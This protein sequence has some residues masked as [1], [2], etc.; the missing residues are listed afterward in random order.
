MGD[1]EV[2]GYITGMSAAAQCSG[3]SGCGG[4]SGA[5]DGASVPPGGSM[6]PPPRDPKEFLERTSTPEGEIELLKEAMAGKPNG[7]SWTE[8][9]RLGRAGDP[10]Y[11]ELAKRPLVAAL[12][13]MVTTV[14]QPRSDNFTPPE[15]TPW[16]GKR[17]VEDVKAGLGFSHQYKIVGESW[18]ISSHES[19][20]N[21]FAL[22]YAGQALEVT[23]SVLSRIFSEEMYGRSITSAHDEG[24]P[25]LVKL[26]NSGS[27]LPY[28]DDLKKMFGW[29]DG[30]E[31]A[32]GWRRSL[33]VDCSFT[34]MLSW[35]HHALHR[36]IARL[37]TMML[38]RIHS[39]SERHPQAPIWRQS[40]NVSSLEN[41]KGRSTDELINAL[42]LLSTMQQAGGLAEEAGETDHLALLHIIHQKMLTKNL[43][44]QVHPPKGYDRLSPGEHSKSEAWI[45]L[46]S[47]PGAGIYLGIKEGVTKEQFASAL[48]A[49]EDV[50]NLLNFIQVKRGDVFFIPAGTMHA[51]G[52]GVLLMEPQETSETTY[53]VY[54]YG[55]LDANKR[56][57]ELKIDSAMAVTEWG[58]KRGEDAVQWF[59][60]TPEVMNAGNAG[61]ARVERVLNETFFETARLTFGRGASHLSD[62]D[63]SIKAYTVVE[64]AVEVYKGD[65]GSPVGIYQKGQ[66]FIIPVAMG[67]YRMTGVTDGA[68]VYETTVFSLDGAGR[69]K[70]TSSISEIIAK[71]APEMQSRNAQFV[72]RPSRGHILMINPQGYA[73]P[74]VPMSAPDTGGQI[75]YLHSKARM[76]A[77]MGYKVSIVTRSFKPDEQY[78]SYGDRMG[79]DFLSG[80]GDMVRYVFVPGLQVENAPFYRKEERHFYS[81]LPSMARN[82]ALFVDDEARTQKV[83]PWDYFLYV[84]THY[85]DGGKVGQRLVRIWDHMFVNKYF[86][87][88]F[89]AVLGMRSEQDPFADDNIMGNLPYYFGKRVMAAWYDEMGSQPSYGS[90][91]NMQDVLRWAATKL[92]WPPDR[93]ARLLSNST[94]AAIGNGRHMLP[95][96]FDAY[97]IG[98]RLLE[99]A[100][101]LGRLFRYIKN[102]NRHVWTP[103]SLGQLK[104]DRMIADNL[105]LK[106]PA[107]F[108]ALNFAQR[109]ASERELLSGSLS[110]TDLSGELIQ[111]M[112]PAK[113]VVFT[114]VEIAEAAMR[115]GMPAT[116][117]T[118]SFVPGTDP[119]QYHQRDSVNHPDIQLL[120]ND[121][122]ERGVVPA[123]ILDALM[124]NPQNFNVI[125]EAGRMD[126]SKR[127][128]LLIEAMASLPPNTVMLI[129]GGRDRAGIYDG[130]K[131]RIERLGLENRV[132]LLGMVP[133][134]VMGPLMSIPHG[135]ADDQFRLA[136]VASA[137]G[138]EGWGMAVQDGT[139]GGMPLVGSDRIPYAVHL[140]RAANA[141]V[142][143]PS[144]GSETEEVARYAEALRSMIDNPPAARDT[145]TRSLKIAQQYEWKTLTENAMAQLTGLLFMSGD[146]SQTMVAG[147]AIAVGGSKHV[148]IFAGG[149][150]T[151]FRPY[152]SDEVPKQFLPITHQ[153]RTM[154]Q[155]TAERFK[156]FVPEEN[157]WISTNARHVDL[158]GEQLPNVPRSNVIGEPVARNTAPAIASIMYWI[159]R[160]DPEA[161]VLL[162]PA[163]HFIASTETLLGQVGE[164]YEYAAATGAL[165][166][167][168]IPPTWASP[169]YGYIERGGSDA[170]YTDIYRVRRFVEKPDAKKAQTYLDGGNF[171]WNS[172]MFVWS[173]KSFL[174]NLAHYQPLMYAG[175][176]A[177]YGRSSVEA[178]LTSEMMERFFTPLHPISI[179]YALMEPA[180]V[181]NRVVVLPFKS[182]WSDV[183]TWQS[184]DRMVREGKAA[185]PEVV[186]EHM[187][188]KLAA[189]G[190]Q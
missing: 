45:I 98:F 156:G 176:E 40:L 53:R 179:D 182:D 108:H 110:G 86:K 51:I 155:V 33:D 134:E 57:R 104:E 16:G 165:L 151:R 64:G 82:L 63:G 119:Q 42:R 169:E 43:S 148:V 2:L 162:V 188:A 35:D 94:G 103:H 25:F 65:E 123:E 154:L 159:A 20:P 34:E 17:I 118:I 136:M 7:I 190:G 178:S 68:T 152:S 55:R 75:T 112:P 97:T 31:Y 32:A 56:P 145:A 93:V 28:K 116:K 90:A 30:R 52:A 44:V 100:G 124:Q 88:R 15:R 67:P 174:Q 189:G 58:G 24:L 29:L 84:D 22:E 150:G 6:P 99:T 122:R 142:V 23:I 170:A 83:N 39:T 181:D 72:A 135:E 186:L 47:E 171:L 115:Q 107:A 102:L 92:E 59:R 37:K 127:K 19:F 177:I 77:K 27:W 139:R 85:V 79:V 140:S 130:L 146:V 183:G 132:F 96:K 3:S 87:E 48:R 180:S 160:Q 10:S 128:H 21:V 121:L 18:E 70:P 91:L 173:A 157:I 175:L 166:T 8:M 138:M 167:F 131:G 14:L 1:G 126:M 125:V 60:R 61:T 141:A 71:Q 158:V 101:E 133:E 54:D 50:T 113:V 143:V 73:G 26:V 172:G 69:A 184:L 41:L 129:T 38:Q 76:L 74:K 49:G 187:R 109:I 117:P 62:S 149:S 80:T 89:K 185:P 106:D 120:F 168:G 66:S 144:G 163:D 12:G 161:T 153:D 81:D 147:A 164:A 4:I 114:S 36:G 5:D 13:S 11:A 46:D 137:S 78:A 111:G 95:A 105:I 9:I